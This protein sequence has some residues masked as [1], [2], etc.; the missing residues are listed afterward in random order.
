MFSIIKK[1]IATLRSKGLKEKFGSTLDISK[2]TNLIEHIVKSKNKWSFVFIGPVKVDLEILR[3]NSNLYFFSPV[4]Y[5]DLPK[6]L[7]GIDL[8]I[9]PYKV[10]ELSRYINPLKLKECLA[11]GR[12]VVL[13]PLPEV[14][15]LKEA[16]RIGRNKEEFLEQ[17]S[18][19]LSEPFDQEAA[20][21]V[22]KGEDWS[23]KA[24]QMSQYIEEAIHRKGGFK[25]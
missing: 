21:K 22:Q 18:K 17:I 1:G 14:L 7:A 19:A 20:E 23:F 8:F 10:N 2:L 24:E 5:N 25:N 3:K 15:K 4:P 16:V 6:Y 9:V 11:T 13:T 12:P